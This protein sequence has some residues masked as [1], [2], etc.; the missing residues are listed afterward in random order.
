MLVKEVMSVSRCTFERLGVGFP[1]STRH[2]CKMSTSEK[3]C[4][5]NSS[6]KVKDVRLLVFISGHEGSAIP[7]GHV[8]WIVVERLWRMSHIML[9]LQCVKNEG[10]ILSLV[11]GI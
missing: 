2:H 3:Q 6:L 10:N 5:V 11:L 9:V 1:N 8:V 4:T 7:L